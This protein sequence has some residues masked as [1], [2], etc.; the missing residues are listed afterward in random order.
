MCSTAFFVLFMGLT[1]LF[2]LTFTFIYSIFSKKF[3]VSAKQRISNRSLKSKFLLF[4]VLYIINTTHL[5]IILLT[6]SIHSQK[7][8]H[9]LFYHLKKLLYQLY[10]IILQYTQH[11]NFYF[12]IL[13][14]KIIYLHNKIIHLY[15]K[16][17]YSKEREKM[18]QWRGDMR[19]CKSCRQNKIIIFGFAIHSIIAI[20]VMVLQ[21]YCKSF[22]LYHA[23]CNQLLAFFFFFWC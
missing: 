11:S 4:Q 21:Q 3:L 8:Y 17:I 2:Q 18:S 12:T 1:I 10:N 19:P 23:S 13:R 9:I 7:F 14:I 22:Q 6:Q 15:N 16:I 20:F 5:L